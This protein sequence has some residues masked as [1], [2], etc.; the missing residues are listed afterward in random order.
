MASQEDEEAKKRVQEAVWAWTQR[1]LVLAVIFGFGFFAG[2]VLY[3]YG[4]Q[5]A[6]GAA[7]PDREA[8][9][10]DRR[11]Q[12]QARRRRGQAHGHRGPPHAVPE[13]PAEGAHGGRRAAEAASADGSDHLPGSQ[14]GE[15]LVRE[16]EQLAVDVVVCSP[17]SGPSGAAR[18]ACRTASPPPRARRPRRAWP[19]AAGRWII[20]R[21]ATQLGM[22]ACEMV[23]AVGGAVLWTSAELARAWSGAPVRP[24]RRRPS[25]DCSPRTGSSRASAPLAEPTLRA[26]IARSDLES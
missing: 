17:I 21:G 13:R 22:L 8:G 5:G 10:D 4:P 18:R 23:D 25:S 24:P 26:T 7:R 15:L 16:P 19:A 2:W 14:P 11:V 12:E 9:R 1:L 6:P 3:G 20:S